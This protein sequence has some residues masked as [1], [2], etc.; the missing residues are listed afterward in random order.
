MKWEVIFFRF[1]TYH[2]PMFWDL[3]CN[4]L[5]DSLLSTKQQ[6]RLNCALHLSMNPEE[7]SDQL[8]D[9]IIGHD[10]GQRPWNRIGTSEVAEFLV[11]C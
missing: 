3:K 2:A 8:A 5:D 10:E 1:E 4:D 9:Y 6:I 7:N 11:V